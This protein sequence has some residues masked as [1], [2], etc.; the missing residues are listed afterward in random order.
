MSH[1]LNSSNLRSNVLQGLLR[2]RKASPRPAHFGAPSPPAGDGDIHRPHTLPSSGPMPLHSRGEAHNLVVRGPGAGP[3]R[4]HQYGP[5]WQC[6]IFRFS[7]VRWGRKRWEA[8]GEE[9]EDEE[10]PQ[11]E[12]EIPTFGVVVATD[13]GTL[14]PS[15]HDT[16]F[17][18]LGRCHDFGGLTSKTSFSTTPRLC[19]ICR[20]FL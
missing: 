2:S 5:Q 7:N 20:S 11:V 9:G 3:S 15:N 18:K 17:R 14:P 13:Q 12:A 6:S 16:D 10:W 8:A 4:C 19:A 1:L